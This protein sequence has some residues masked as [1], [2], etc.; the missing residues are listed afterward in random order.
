VKPGITGWAQVDGFRGAID[1]DS[2]RGRI[3]HDLYYIDHWSL[4]FDLRILML[5]FSAKAFRNAC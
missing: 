3:Q 1:P 2:V 4:W 5:T